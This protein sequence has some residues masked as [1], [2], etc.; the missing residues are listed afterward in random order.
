MTVTGFLDVSH[1]GDLRFEFGDD[2]R[3]ATAVFV[4]GEPFRDGTRLEPGA[5]RIH[6][7]AMLTGDVWRFVPLWTGADLWSSGVL[8]TLRRP[9]RADHLLRPLG[10]WLVTLVVLVWLIA[11][12]ASYAARLRSPLVLGWLVA[13]AACLSALAATGRVDAGRWCVIALAGAALLPVPTRLRN[14]S[15]AFALIGI[16]WLA[17]IAAAGA[18]DIGRFWFYGAGHDFWTYQ[19]YAYRIV[20]QGYWLEGGSQTF[21]FQPLYRWIVSALH[22]IFGDSSVGERFWDAAG[23]LI[24]A[25]LAW[26]VTDACAGFRA[27]VIAAVLTLSVVALGTPWPLIGEGLSEITSAGFIYL[28]AFIALRGGRGRFA[29]ALAASV[30][31]TLGFYARLNNLPMAISVAI[32]ALPARFRVRDLVGQWPWRWPAAWRTALT[33]PA[34]IAVGLPLFTWRTWHYTGVFNPLYGTSGARLAIWQPGMP[35]GT[36]LVGAISSAMMVLT[37]NDPAQFDWRALPLLC[38]AAAAVLALLGV[39]R[40]RDLPAAPVLFFLAG[41]SSAFIAR[42]WAY[43]GRFSVPIIGITCAL[44]VCAVSNLLKARMAGV[45]RQS[46]AHGFGM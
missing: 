8:A 27:G 29:V 20:M 1:A 15:G 4:D 13:A 3:G 35:A 44:T 31:A 11:W 42:G 30:V 34:V 45:S 14:L 19:R 37:L 25:L 23:V 21:Y 2:M 33:I 39:P 6:V 46:T 7:D 26:R 9:S 32:F 24:T 41:I 28:A 5:H 12:L 36:A 16:P 22:L 40:F 10:G 43:T 18:G 17:F 38:G